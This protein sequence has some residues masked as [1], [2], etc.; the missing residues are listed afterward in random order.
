MGRPLCRQHG[1][2]PFMEP[3]GFSFSTAFRSLEEIVQYY[4]SRNS[5]SKCTLPL[6]LVPRT[7]PT[8]P[9]DA[10]ACRM[11]NCAHLYG[12]LSRVV[13]RRKWTLCRLHVA[14]IKRL[15]SLTRCQVTVL[16]GKSSAGIPES[17][18]VC[19]IDYL[20]STMSLYLK[21]LSSSQDLP[22]TS[23]Y[24]VY[25]KSTIMLHHRSNRQMPKAFLVALISC[26]MYFTI[27]F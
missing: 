1:T 15:I 23:C 14:S 3:T 7:K 20:I 5:M 25:E 8:F 18:G 12:W 17:Q 27:P 11:P 4:Q 16:L 24:Q 6:C 9:H 26:Y 21:T 2:D 13:W 19:T 22:D 10:L